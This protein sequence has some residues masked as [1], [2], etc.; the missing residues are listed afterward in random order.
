MNALD[1]EPRA[2][3]RLWV[4]A[5]LTALALHF[6]GA[7][8]AVA[9]LKDAEVDDE[10]GAPAIEIGLEFSSPKLEPT[11]LPP[12]PDSDAS[13]A[14]PALAEQKAE[15][16]ESDLPKDTPTETEDADR[17]VTPNEVKK[18]VEDEAKIAAVQTQASQESIAAEATATPSSESMPQGTRSVAPAQGTGETARRVRATWQKELIAHLDR[19]KRYPA[20][21]VQ[22]SAEIL[23]GFTLDRLGHVL[24]ASVVKGS[25]D[26]AFDEAA[27]AMIRRSDPVPQPPPLVADEGLNFT[28]P[29]IFR[30]KGKS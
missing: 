3:R 21:R 17:V 11:D 2:S 25:G 13:V 1:T 4:F 8:L 10:L 12:G 27:L 28:L 29:V 22:K 9:H 15:L 14:S 19:H 5:G 18:P 26:A 23:V 24:S 20:E 30:V 16:K 6:G 7:A